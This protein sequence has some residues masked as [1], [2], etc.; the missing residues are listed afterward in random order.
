MLLN[1][2]KPE[3][4][5]RLKKEMAAN[6]KHFSRVVITR[7]K[8]ENPHFVV[9]VE[10]LAQLAEI[11]FREKG[12]ARPEDARELALDI[13]AL[14]FRA[15]ELAGLDGEQ[16][17]PAER[18]RNVMMQDPDIAEGSKGAAAQDEAGALMKKLR[19]RKGPRKDT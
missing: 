1:S 7:A 17:S 4:L 10:S 14:C 18:R 16:Q 2:V 13:G 9:L 5:L 3:H 19:T 15:L 8:V 11:E 12:F 6:P